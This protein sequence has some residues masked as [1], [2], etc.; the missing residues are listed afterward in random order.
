MLDRFDMRSR[1]PGI[2]IHYITF[3]SFETPRGN[4]VYLV[5]G[6]YVYMG[7]GIASSTSTRSNATPENSD[8]SEKGMRSM[9]RVGGRKRN[10]S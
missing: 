8:E 4:D 7:M 6:V 9:T 1:V 5:Y 2:L 3:L 10:Q